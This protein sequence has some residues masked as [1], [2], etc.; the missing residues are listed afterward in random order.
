MGKNS[1][2]CDCC[3]LEEAHEALQVAAGLEGGD[4]AEIKDTLR[5]LP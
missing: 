1:A 3:Q 5:A 2:A 4:S